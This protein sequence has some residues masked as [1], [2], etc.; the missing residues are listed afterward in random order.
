MNIMYENF[1]IMDA[2]SKHP[3]TD[4]EP[5]TKLQMAERI[6]LKDFCFVIF[7]SMLL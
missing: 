4:V 5:Q 6:Y 3:I 2:I 7:S 1:L